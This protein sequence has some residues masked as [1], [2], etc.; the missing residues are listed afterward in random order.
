MKI[1]ELKPGMNDVSIRAKVAE[2]TEPKQIT[3]KFGTQT[4][5]TNITLEDDTGTIP[6]ALWGAQSEGIT[7]GTEVEVTGGFTKE[8][9]GTLQLGVGKNGSIKT[10]E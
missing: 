6:M 10:V 8:F 1:N 2:V 4:S 3:T 5:L 7:E 9:R